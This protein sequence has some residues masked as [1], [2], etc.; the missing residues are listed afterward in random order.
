[1]FHNVAFEALQTTILHRD[2]P[3]LSLMYE[4]TLLQIS[5]HLHCYG[6]VSTPPSFEPTNALHRVD[7]PCPV[8]GNIAILSYWTAV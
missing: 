3:I 6:H 2:I 4:P 8:M 1:M 7:S 5:G